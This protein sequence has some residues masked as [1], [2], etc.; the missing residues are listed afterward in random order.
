MGACRKASPASG[1]GLVKSVSVEGDPCAT[2]YQYD[3]AGRVISATQ[4]DT[5]DLYTYAGDSV[6]YTHSV[7]AAI[8]YRYIYHLDSRGMATSYSTLISGGL[9]ATY[10][11]S[12]DA[13]GH[14]SS[15]TD[16]TH[17]GNYTEYLIVNGNTIYDTV[18][19]TTS[20]NAA[21]S[22]TYYPGTTNTL[23]HSNLGL[24]WLGAASANLKKTETYSG[25]GNSYTLHYYYELDYLN[26]VSRR[27][28]KVN[29]S[30]VEMREYEYYGSG[31]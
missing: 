16:V 18:V 20:G 11:I 10:A 4:C 19:S 15:L 13:G 31:D 23:S 17:P 9:E 26:G 22:R 28:T 7:A 5:T 21:V 6:T 25:N 30:V 24:A 2:I 27:I 8:A 14:R 1:P 29:D 3:D 12:Y